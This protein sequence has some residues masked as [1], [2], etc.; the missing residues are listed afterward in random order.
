MNTFDSREY[1][2]KAID[3]FVSCIPESE[4]QERLD[5]VQSTPAT[6]HPNYENS[7]EDILFKYIVTAKMFIDS[8]PYYDC[9]QGSRI[10]PYFKAIGIELENIKSIINF[11]EKIKEISK[12]TCP[13]PDSGIFEM[14]VA[15]LHKRNGF[16]KVEFIQTRPPKKTPDILINDGDEI[17]VECKRMTKKS[18]Y[19]I[20]EEAKWSALWG[21]IGQEI[22]KSKLSA[23]IDIVFHDELQDFEDNYLSDILMHRIKLVPTTFPCT[24]IDNERITVCS[25]PIDRRRIDTHLAKYLVN[26]KSPTLLKLVL[27]EHDHHVNSKLI[28]KYKAS[29]EC[30]QL[31]DGIGFIAAVTWRCDSQSALD[32]KSRHIKKHLA[33]AIEQIPNGKYGIIHFGIEA[34]EGDAIEKIRVVKNSG[35]IKSFDFRDKKIQWIHFHILAPST[36]PQEDWIFEE[37]VESYR[38]RLVGIDM[39]ERTHIIPFDTVRNGYKWERKDDL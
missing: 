28:M 27:G 6:S 9:F 31:V 12:K 37:T 2:K 20:D 4:Q 10:I 23:V 7:S 3:L 35:I 38:A 11:D 22:Y 8:S 15:A 13:N 1:I 26:L 34:V 30:S 18:Q 36:T 25:R 21:D 19:S 5:N 16:N 24:V 33:E 32:K 39:G 29:S 14:L 17:F